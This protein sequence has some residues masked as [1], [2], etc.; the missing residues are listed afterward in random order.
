MPLFSAGHLKQSNVVAV[1]NGVKH[2]TRKNLTYDCLCTSNS[3]RILHW[4]SDF[5]KRMISSRMMTSHR[6]D[7]S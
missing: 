2:N 1:T 5:E 7:S 3:E 4:K 6:I